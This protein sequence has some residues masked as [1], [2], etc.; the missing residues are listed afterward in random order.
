MMTVI[1]KNGTTQS[2]KLLSNYYSN[3]V[4]VKSAIVTD[5]KIL[6][7]RQKY[8]YNNYFLLNEIN[9]LIIFLI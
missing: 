3:Y 7:N 1:L 5:D 9:V 8:I 2:S 6:L 4:L